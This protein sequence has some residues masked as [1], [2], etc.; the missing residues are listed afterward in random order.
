VESTPENTEDVL[1]N[2]QAEVVQNEDKAVQ[3]EEEAVQNEGK[4]DI[5]QVRNDAMI[6]RVN[7]LA[8]LSDQKK[9]EEIDKKTKEKAE[10]AQQQLPEETRNQL[11]EKGYDDKFINDY[12]L[13]RVTL[14]EVK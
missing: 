13:L 4:V 7:L 14:N 10:L 2:A 5:Q 8:S 1:S 6:A 11:N 3:N 9:A 12:I